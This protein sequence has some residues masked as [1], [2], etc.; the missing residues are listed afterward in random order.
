MKNRI[1]IQNIN[2]KPVFSVPTG[3]FEGLER[4]IV[5]V[6]T[7]EESVLE[8]ISNEIPFQVPNRYFEELPLKIQQ[9]AVPQTKVVLHW[10]YRRAGV[11]LLAACMVGILVWVTLPQWQGPIGNEP[12][13]QVSDTDIVNYLHSQ[14]LNGYELVEQLEKPNTETVNTADDTF[15]D[16][17][18]ISDKEILQ[19]LEDRNLTEDI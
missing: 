10:N 15:I 4:R 9:K 1:S 13:S 7:E 2:K 5:Q 3:Y 8:G 19:H 16:S 14:D 17:L 18:N 11:A 6:S 12:L